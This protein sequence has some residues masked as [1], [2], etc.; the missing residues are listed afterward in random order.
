MN[1]EAPA[2]PPQVH[3]LNNPAPGR[4]HVLPIYSWLS[5]AHGYIPPAA[6]PSGLVGLRVDLFYGYAGELDSAIIWETFEVE[7]KIL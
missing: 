1:D 3:L 2:A 7:A 4:T 5:S 6:R